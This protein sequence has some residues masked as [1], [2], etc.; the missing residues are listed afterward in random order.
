MTPSSSH[1]SLLQDVSTRVKSEL[2][3]NSNDVVWVDGRKFHSCP[4]SSYILPCDEE[5]ID[6][7]HLLHFM[8][9]FAIQGNYL[10]P[11]TDVLRKGA[12]VLDIGC[13]PG[14][15]TMEMA[16]EYPKSTIVG[17]D[18]VPLFPKDIK[19]TNCL[20]YQNNVL[21]GLPFQ[22]STFDYVFMRFMGLG[23]ETDQWETLLN[24]IL[25]ILKP[26][27]WIEIV[28]VDSELHRT[29]PTTKMFNDHLMSLIASKQLDQQSGRRLKE[30]F[31]A[32][33]DLTNINTTFI[34]C[35]A[36]Q[37]AGKLGQLTLQ[38]WK[39]YYQ[40]FRPQI[41]LHSGMDNNEYNEK[42]ETCWSEV[43]EY[44]TFENVH[45]AYA[46]KKSV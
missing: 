40:A 15:W 8:I 23:I 34:S 13:G 21:N 25:R 46:Q 19:P 4:G 14:S 9:R 41:C 37:W 22:D 2:I 17:V 6:R 24:E 3:F 30:R 11:V 39:S 38:S 29:G 10:A 18:M 28:E 45:F 12:N 7:L 33:D 42:L 44:K 43:D 31:E 20:F 27:G 5:E 36:G 16:G 35:P 1:H 32:R 26:G